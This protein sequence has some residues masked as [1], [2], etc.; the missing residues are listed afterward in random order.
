MTGA[1][2]DQVLTAIVSIAAERG[3]DHVS[4]REV[5]AEAGVSIGTVQYYCR[6]KD[7]LLV[8]GFRHIMDRINARVAG[9]RRSGQ[10]APVLRSALSEFLPLDRTRGREA[11]AYLAFAA[12]AAFSPTLA[13]VQ[14]EVLSD[15]R[16]RCADTF[17]LAQERGQ[18][19]T[20]YVAADAAA[21]TAALVDGLILHLLTDPKGLSKNAA[22]RI[23][24]NHLGRY[25]ELDV[26]P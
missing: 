8:L 22:L 25:L 4:I 14:R 15:L 24:D 6:S 18:A 21:S 23:L 26:R 11:R 20:D 19:K 7:E 5:A 16:K 2:R 17:R 12:Q 10:V 1:T 9:K 3:L 13:A